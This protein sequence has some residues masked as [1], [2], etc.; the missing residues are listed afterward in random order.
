MKIQLDENVLYSGKCHCVGE[1]LDVDEKAGNAL[2]QR[3]LG[4]AVQE[5]D[6]T[7]DALEELLAG[8]VTST[9]KRRR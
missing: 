3:G 5:Q 2:V 7:N 8:A 1:I 9:K 6:S 4:H